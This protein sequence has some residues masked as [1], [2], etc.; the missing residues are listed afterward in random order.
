MALI[1]SLTIP[2]TH[3]L[4]VPTVPEGASTEEATAIELEAAKATA[5][6]MGD[7]YPDAYIRIAH[8]R[9]HETEAVAVVLWYA[10]ADER[11]K[12][13]PC[14]QIKEYLVPLVVPESAAVEES[15][16]YLKTL[17]EF[18]GAVDFTE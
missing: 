10:S 8:V 16:P 6:N 2:P 3:L 14:V 7:V 1:G 5:H 11:F 15:Y 12:G 13:A 17:P 9:R 4:E 18:E